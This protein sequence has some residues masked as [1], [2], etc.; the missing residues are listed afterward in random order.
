MVRSSMDIWR[1]ASAPLS[2]WASRNSC[3]GLLLLL[4]LSSGFV[5]PSNDDLIP[6]LLTLGLGLALIINELEVETSMQSW[7]E[8][9]IMD[10]MMFNV[11]ILLVLLLLFLLLAMLPK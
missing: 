1:T 3:S 10:F 4:P 9:K 2:A 6:R 11:E 5:W 8:V 7:S